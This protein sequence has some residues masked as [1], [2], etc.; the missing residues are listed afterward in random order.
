MVL[1]A[2]F[3][4]IGYKANIKIIYKQIKEQ[5]NA[6][7]LGNE[8]SYDFNVLMLKLHPAC[9]QLRVKLY[10]S[11]TRHTHNEVKS[12]KLLKN[13]RTDRHVQNQYVYRS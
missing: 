4:C 9:N 7:K 8:C 2:R 5:E 13:R 10:W 11:L 12:V 3:D 1:I 6:S